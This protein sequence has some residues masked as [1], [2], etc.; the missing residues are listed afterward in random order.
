MAQIVSM[1]VDKGT[2]PKVGTWRA[3]FLNPTKPLR[4]AGM[5]MEPPV[6]E[7]MPM[8]AAPVATETA[9]PED[10]PPGT[11]P[12]PWLMTAFPVLASQAAGVP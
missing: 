8:K 4:A 5:R 2:A 12:L 7:P 11:W 1:V 10:D 6:S 9:A 3:V